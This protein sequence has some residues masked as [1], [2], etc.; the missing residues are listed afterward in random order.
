MLG[1]E[2]VIRL[3][4]DYGNGDPWP[5]VVFLL[6]SGDRGN[7]PRML[8]NRGPLRADLPAIVGLPQCL[9]DRS[10]ETQSIAAF[11]VH[12]ASRYR[13]DRS[14][15]YLVGY[16]MGGYGVWRTAAAY[17]DLVAA[18]VPIC[19][20]G[21]PHDADSL[22][23]LPIWAFHGADDEVIPVNATQQMID[24]VR[25]SGGDPRLTVIRN[26]GHYI[27][28]TVCE[29]SDLWEWLFKHRRSE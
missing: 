24:A 22:V 8:R 13:V 4:D 26:A 20:G 15:I 2:F 18:I 16:S 5:L 7:D 10:W 6:G 9:P 29:Q 12:V 28:E 27:C 3:P 21:N 14:R 11:V 19:G 1:R 25:S 17:P 23:K